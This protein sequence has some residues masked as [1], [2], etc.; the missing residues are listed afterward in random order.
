MDKG[1][2]WADK[3]ITIIKETETTALVDGNLGLGLYIGPYCMNL[4]IEK[5]KKY[6]V[7]FVVAQRSTHYGIA[8]Y[9][10]TMA[11]EQGCV[12][13]SGTN[14]RGTFTC[15]RIKLDDRL[16]FSRKNNPIVC[17]LDLP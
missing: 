2:L 8:G 5:A 12:G 6:G 17:T 11:T 10:S 16:F 14:A 13:F 1:I 15:N 9:Y 4:A 7:G 3:P